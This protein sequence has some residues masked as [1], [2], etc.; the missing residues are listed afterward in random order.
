MAQYISNRHSNG[1]ALFSNSS[2]Y[3][4]RLVPLEVMLAPGF[5]PQRSGIQQDE[6]VFLYGSDGWV[7]AQCIGH[8][9]EGNALL[10]QAQLIS[11]A[12]IKTRKAA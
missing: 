4:D 12:P 1:E 3:K 9:V 10:D 6:M 7:M 2:G 5:F 11:T 8:D